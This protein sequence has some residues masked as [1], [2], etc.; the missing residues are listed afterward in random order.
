M[1]ILIDI[2]KEVTSNNSEQIMYVGSS[3]ARFKLAMISSLSSEECVEI[4]E[5]LG[6]KKSKN[7]EKA[8]ATLYN[9]KHK[10][11]K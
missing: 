3:R 1:I 2:D 11:T 4:L 6:N 9:A 8:I 10:K 7:P 5:S